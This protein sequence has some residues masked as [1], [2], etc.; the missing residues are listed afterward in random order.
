LNSGVSRR[1]EADIQNRAKG[2]GV[3]K[4]L[5]LVLFALA[6]TGGVAVISIISTAMS[7]VAGCEDG[8]C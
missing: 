1:N 8:G 7:V 3:R 4:F 6:L 5:V 2:I